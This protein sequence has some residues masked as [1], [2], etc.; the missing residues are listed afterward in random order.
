MFAPHPHL[1]RTAAVLSH[2]ITGRDHALGEAVDGTCAGGGHGLGRGAW[3]AGG[4]VLAT[5]LALCSPA[6]L[7]V[8]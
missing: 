8:A 2:A 5:W 1:P 3:G 6:G 4:R 7:R